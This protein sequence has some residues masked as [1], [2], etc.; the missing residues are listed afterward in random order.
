MSPELWF[1]IASLCFGII[2]SFFAAMASVIAYFVKR[3]ESARDLTIAELKEDVEEVKDELATYKGHIGVGDQKLQEIQTDL[4]DH[5][6]REEQIFWKKVDALGDSHRLFSEAVLT[7][8]ASMEARLPNGEIE[9]MSKAI[10]RI[11]ARMENVQRD[12][13]SAI[14]HVEE[15]NREAEEWKR[16]I[17]ALEGAALRR[18]TR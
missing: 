17:V 18:K 7:R 12:S 14:V 11:E 3:S 6:I 2:S 13:A 4:R 9:D 1:A 10:A 8:M 16:R 5:V 15:H